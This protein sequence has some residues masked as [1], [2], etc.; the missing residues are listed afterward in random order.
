M[1]KWLIVTKWGF[2]NFKAHIIEKLSNTVYK[3]SDF[4]INNLYIKPIS[5][6]ILL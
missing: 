6:V 3:D 5:A 1:G 2:W 4:F